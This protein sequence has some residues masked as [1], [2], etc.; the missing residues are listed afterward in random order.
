MEVKRQTG[1]RVDSTLTFCQSPS[2]V[3]RG[4]GAGRT[5]EQTQECERTHERPNEESNW[6][7]NQ[8]INKLEPTFH[9]PTNATTSAATTETGYVLVS[10]TDKLALAWGGDVRA[11]G[12]CRQHRL[13]V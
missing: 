4:G 6:A 7:I 12:R 9:H 13:V 11:G 2:V 1:G 3:W 8:P 5:K 10:G